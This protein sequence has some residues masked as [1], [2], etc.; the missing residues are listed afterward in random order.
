MAKE[1]L[2]NGANEKSKQQRQ[3]KK[4]TSSYGKAN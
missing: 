1:M 2:L 3:D 4:T